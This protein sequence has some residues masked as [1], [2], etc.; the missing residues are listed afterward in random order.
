MHIPRSFA[1]AVAASLLALCSL[2]ASAA[3]TLDIDASGT[4]QASTDGALILRYLSGLRGNALVDGAL[5][6]G[7][8]RS[9][10]AIESYLS[11]L[12]PSLDID[13]NGTVDGATDGL[14]ISRYLAG[15]RGQKLI[16]GAVG[17]GA[18]RTSP[19]A[20]RNYLANLVPPAQSSAPTGCSISATPSSS[21][22]APRP[23]GTSVTLTASCAGGTPPI[24]YAWDNGSFGSVRVVYPSA[25]TTYSVV[26]SNAA[27]TAPAVSTTVYMQTQSGPPVCSTIDVAW[28]ASGQTRPTTNG[29]TTQ[30]IAFRFTIPFTFNPPLNITHT[31]Q[32]AI[33]E[34]PGQPVVS[35]EFTVSKTSCDFTSGNYLVSHI[36]TGETATTFSFTVNNPNS[37]IAN[38]NFQS[39]DVIYVNVRNAINGA[40]SCNSYESCD[41]IFDLATPNR[42]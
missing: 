23:L 40:P 16:R 1:A 19:Q 36:G 14:L 33:A 26:P 2:Q 11:A 6:S 13:G 35:R 41:I 9:T 39:G 7:A 21:P 28:P 12:T 32:I 24:T 37:N 4:A 8:T 10:S 3:E 30:T 27:G 20:V 29:F 15:L 34:V 38:T 18:S 22:A 5:D 42:Y 17:P 25:T 31:G